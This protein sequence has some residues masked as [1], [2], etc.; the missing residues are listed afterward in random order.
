M[1]GVG[2]TGI[3]MDLRRGAELRIGA[4]AEM[5]NDAPPG[6]EAKPV[7]EGTLGPVVAAIAHLLGHGDDGFLHDVPRLRLGQP[8]FDGN[9]VDQLPIRI[10]KILPTAVI[11]PIAEAMDQA[12]PRGSRVRGAR[13]PKSSW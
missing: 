4:F 11:A 12:R 3:L 5:I 2:A 10:E 9:G 13:F 1:N 6:D 7:L 8:G